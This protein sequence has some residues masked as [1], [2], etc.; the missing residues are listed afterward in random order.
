MLVINP[1][2]C[3]VHELLRMM[4]WET[5]ARKAMRETHGLSPKL[6]RQGGMQWGSPLALGTSSLQEVLGWCLHSHRGC[7]KLIEQLT[8]MC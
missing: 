6:G 7:W 1:F 3:L 5:E 2:P 4:L 8:A